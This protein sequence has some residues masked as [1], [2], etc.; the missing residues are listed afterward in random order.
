METET[1]LVFA[2]GYQ[3]VKD[4]LFFYFLCSFTFAVRNFC[5]DLTLNIVYIIN[6]TKL[7]ASKNEMFCV[8]VKGFFFVTCVL[9]I[10]LKVV[11]EIKVDSET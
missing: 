6:N 10:F 2:R 7:Y 4:E 3:R 8:T 11:S 9:P 5:R 1:R